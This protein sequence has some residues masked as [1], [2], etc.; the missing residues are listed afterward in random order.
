MTLVD[1]KFARFI[2]DG[3]AIGSEMIEEAKAQLKSDPSAASKKLVTAWIILNGVAAVCQQREM[4]TQA[5]KVETL[6]Q[7]IRFMGGE[8][9]MAGYSLMTGVP[10]SQMAFIVTPK[11]PLKDR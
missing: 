3:S 4:F 11:E 9:A 5:A 8:L 7:K 2:K 10:D 1:I 6:R